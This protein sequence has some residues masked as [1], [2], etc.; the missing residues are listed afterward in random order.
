MPEIDRLS[1]R[2]GEHG[3]QTETRETGGI[4]CFSLRVH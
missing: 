2:L 4:D 3:V 1:H